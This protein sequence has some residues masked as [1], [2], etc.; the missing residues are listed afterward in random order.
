[1]NLEWTIDHAE[2]H[3]VDQRDWRLCY[4]LHDLLQRFFENIT[5]AYL[6]MSINTLILRCNE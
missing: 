6:E 5:T 4:D 2:M 3:T 1:M